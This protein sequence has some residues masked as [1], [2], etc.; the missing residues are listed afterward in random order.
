MKPHTNSLKAAVLKT[1]GTYS[2]GLNAYE[3]TQLT[4]E[5]YPHA[6][7]TVQAIRRVLTDLIKEKRVTKTGKE[8]CLTCYM[9]QAF[10]RLVKNKRVEYEPYGAQYQ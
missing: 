2:G 7:G 1:L 8:L 6:G 3:L 10:Y 9:S 4:A 5:A